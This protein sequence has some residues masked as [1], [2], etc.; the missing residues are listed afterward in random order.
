MPEIDH[1]VGDGLECVVQPADALEA[2]QQ[3]PELVFPGKHPLDRPEA[4]FENG[5]LKDR[6]AAPLGLLSAAG[7][8]V[9]VDQN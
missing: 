9:D 2:Q 4:L 5:R 6:L 1:R 3:S 7:I 8:G